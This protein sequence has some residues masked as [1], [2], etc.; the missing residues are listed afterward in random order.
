MSDNRHHLLSPGPEFDRIINHGVDYSDGPIRFGVMPGEAW[1]RV[2]NLY[3][4][5]VPAAP[6]EDFPTAIVVR[7][8]GR[9]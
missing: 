1:F 8:S 6:S 4:E 5:D 3:V 7:W 2:R 9:R